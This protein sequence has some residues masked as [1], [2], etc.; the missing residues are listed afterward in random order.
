MEMTNITSCEM[1]ESITQEF[2]T[3]VENFWNKFSKIVNITKQSQAWWNKECNRDLAVYQMSKQRSDWIKYRKM[4][5]LTK[6]NFFDSKIQEIV[7]FNKRL[8]DLI[9]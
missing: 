5:K 1:L 3:I 6:R 7:S 9:N 4:V 2:A 8:W